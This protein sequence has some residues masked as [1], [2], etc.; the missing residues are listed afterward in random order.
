LEAKNY[1]IR[2]A[3][4]S[5]GIFCFYLMALTVSRGALLGVAIATVIAFEKVLKRSF[6]P[7]LGVLCLAWF[8]YVSGVFDNLIGYYVHRGAEE[9][10]RSHLWSRAFRGFLDS[11]WIGV[12]I[13]NTLSAGGSF[14]PHNSF[15]FFGQSSGVIPLA[16]YIAFLAQATRGALRARTLK[17]PDSPYI[18]PLVSFALLNAMLG[19]VRF[20][21]HWLMVV[22]CAGASWYY[23]SLRVPRMGR[24]AQR[25]TES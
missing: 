10:G 9:S 1:I 12:G 22:F 17:T 19:D 2:T 3:S 13:S 23:Y 6:L 15:L 11:W 25:K 18:L 21:S 14:G 16:L 7:I 5:A 4:W 24:D 8:L 20:M